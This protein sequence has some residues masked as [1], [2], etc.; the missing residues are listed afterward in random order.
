MPEVL[1]KLFCSSL[2]A[3]PPQAPRQTYLSFVRR[4]GSTGTCLRHM[5]WFRPT[6]F[7]GATKERL[8]L[9]SYSFPQSDFPSI[10]SYPPR[11]SSSVKLDT[12]GGPSEN[13]SEK[14]SSL[15]RA[16]S[17][18]Y[19]TIFSQ[20]PLLFGGDRSFFPSSFSILCFRKEKPA[21]HILT[22]LPPARSIYLQRSAITSLIT[23]LLGTSGPRFQSSY[24][25]LSPSP[26]SQYSVFAI[27][28]SA[29]SPSR[30]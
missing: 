14:H 25:I 24:I 10:L 17:K 21:L 8:P 19:L 26:E 13:A 15:A 11:S 1:Q 2:Y 18:L 23:S 29:S 27:K 22:P 12:N 30:D 16:K 20:L 6:S 7:G 28:S 4:I 3:H 9:F 5:S